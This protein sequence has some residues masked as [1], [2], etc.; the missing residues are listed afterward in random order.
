MKL[1][2]LHN[3]VAIVRI[4]NK[5][6]TDSGIVLTKATGEVD[7]AK[8]IAIG[9]E[10][11]SINVNDVLLVDWNKASMNKFDGIPVYMISEDDIVAV[12][13]DSKST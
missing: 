13:E 3:R 5:L 7:R 10:V 6:E 8:A 9:P 12:F 2:P 11:T 4:K 1:V